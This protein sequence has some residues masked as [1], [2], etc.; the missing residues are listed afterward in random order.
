MKSM[1]K[2]TPLTAI[3]AAPNL[4]R[5][6]TCS[7]ETPALSRLPLDA[8]LLKP[9]TSRTRFCPPARPRPARGGIWPLVAAAGGPSDIPT[10]SMGYGR[11][12]AHLAWS[13]GEIRPPFAC[14]MDTDLVRRRSTPLH[15][16]EKVVVPVT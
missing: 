13:T 2:A 6:L 14:D 15:S 16:P 3:S 4:A 12:V 1:R 5:V 11:S 8:H 10:V 7:N 9:S